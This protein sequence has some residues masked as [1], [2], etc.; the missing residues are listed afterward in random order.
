MYTYV[1]S[2]LHILLLIFVIFGPI[3]IAD[4]WCLLDTMNNKK[5]NVYINRLC[6]DKPSNVRS[7]IPLIQGLGDD[8][9]Y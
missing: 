2:H 8:I 1:Y 9:R 4:V 6:T 7:F 3:C 5:H